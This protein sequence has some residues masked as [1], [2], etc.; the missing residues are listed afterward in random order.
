VS[1]ETSIDTRLNAVTALT[2]IVST[3]IYRQQRPRGSALPCVVYQRITSSVVNHAGGVTATKNTRIQVDSLASTASGART[4]ADAV[5]GAISGWSNSGGTP[6][7]SMCHQMSDVDLVAGPDHG[8]DAP[9]YRV[10]QDYEL[11]YS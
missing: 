7:I 9:R 1:L 10:S 11:W 6:S 2:D 3:R 8:E 4:L 5:A